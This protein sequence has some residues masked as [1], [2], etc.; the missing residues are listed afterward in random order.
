MSQIFDSGDNEFIAA[1]DLSRLI[2]NGGLE[3]S[4]WMLP[5]EKLIVVY[6]VLGQQRA[7]LIQQIYE[8]TGISDII[9]GQ[10]NPNETLGAQ[11]MK[12]NFGSLRIDRQRKS[13]EKYARDLVRIMVELISE[14]FSRETLS[15]MSGLSFPTKDQQMQAQMAIQMMQQQL[16]GMPPEMQQ[17]MQAQM[18]QQMQQAKQ[19]LSQPSWEDI[20]AVLKSDLSREYRIDVETD[21]TV[22]ADAQR[23]QQIMAE[24]MNGMGQFFKFASDGINTGMISPEISR[25]IM[26]SFVRKFKLGRDVE[27]EIENFEP[28]QQN[29]AQQ[30]EQ[31]AAQQEQQAKMQET[32]AKAEAAQA[33]M[34]MEMQKMQ[35]ELQMEQQKAQIEAG[36]MQAE[37]E[38]LRE[39]LELERQ[40][41]VVDRQKLADKA[42][43][44]QIVQEQK[45][46]ETIIKND[47]P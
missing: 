44:E 4:I 33:K 42:Q 29:Q 8:I 34:Q 30:Q 20:E 3:K 6:Q 24:F 16:Q 31:Q 47:S 25:K 22:M 35:A 41:V 36:K 14:K 5:I 39:K 10:T 21:S 38:I 45:I 17:Q 1:E 40:K 46:Q 37:V 28:P 11:Q 26:G 13:L 18:G 32:Q 43:Y 12:A 23:D 9:R 7:E 27:D 19:I 2:E 15:L